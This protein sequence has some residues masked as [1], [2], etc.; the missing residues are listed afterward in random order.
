M[1]K[2]LFTVGYGGI[3]PEMLIALLKEHKIDCV[4]DVRRYMSKAFLRAYWAG[5][6]MSAL[7]QNEGIAY[8]HDYFLGNVYESLQDYQS[9]L[10]SEEG[11][12]AVKMAI[13][14]MH[15]DVCYCLLC[16][17]KY[18]YVANTMEVICH[19][20]YVADAMVALLGDDWQVEHLF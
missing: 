11:I 15:Q 17:E 7:L 4:I 3:P 12:I 16:A 10:E 14:D 18:P 19:R 13:K 20:K 5:R 9:W 2:T 8:R 1:M 6:N